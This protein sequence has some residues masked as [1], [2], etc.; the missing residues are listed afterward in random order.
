MNTVSLIGRLTADPETRAG[1]KTESATFR[2]AVPRR[3]SE[4]ADFVDIVT[5][6][7]LAA[8]C[9]EY[10]S[11]GRQVAVVGRLRLNEWVNAD[12]ERR[13]RLQ[14]VADDVE[15]LD[16]PR[17]RPKAE[18]RRRSRAD[19]GPARHG[20]LPQGRRRPLSSGT[21]QGRPPHRPLGGRLICTR[22]A[23]RS[24]LQIHCGFPGADSLAAVGA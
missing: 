18:R 23:P 24:R 11:K 14:V 20:P 17:A 7:K 8:T 22:Q 3:A 13:S 19:P 9:G 2:L 16:S 21:G 5:F 10:L 15:F 4:D 1:E 6:D 12:G